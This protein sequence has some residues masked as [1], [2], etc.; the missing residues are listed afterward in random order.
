MGRLRTKMEG[1]NSEIYTSQ[2]ST[3]ETDGGG[4]AEMEI[5]KD[6][7]CTKY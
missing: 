4:F 2:K 7:I 6:K 3:L 5:F 1:L